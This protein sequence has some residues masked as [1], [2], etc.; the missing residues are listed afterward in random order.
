MNDLSKR[1]PKKTLKDTKKTTKSPKGK[2]SRVKETNNG[3]ERESERKTEKTF[4][5][6]SRPF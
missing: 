1:K 5:E 4:L 2:S 3:R 6:S